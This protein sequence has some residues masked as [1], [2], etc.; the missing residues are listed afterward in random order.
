MSNDKN[1]QK[2]WSFDTDGTWHI[3]EMNA[4]GFDKVDYKIMPLSTAAEYSFIHEKI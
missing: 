1:H 3:S 4:V 2:I